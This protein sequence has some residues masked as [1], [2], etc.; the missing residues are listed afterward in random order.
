MSVPA[1]FGFGVNGDNFA[2]EE[3]FAPNNLGGSSEHIFI[4]GIP[5]LGRE[6]E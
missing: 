6:L 3:I 5:D 1:V 2:A 4:D